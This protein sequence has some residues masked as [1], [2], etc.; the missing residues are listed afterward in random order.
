MRRL[1][2]EFDLILSSPFLRCRTTAEIVAEELGLAKK[3]EMTPRLEP[4]ASPADLVEELLARHAGHENILLVGHE[5]FLSTLISVLISGNQRAEIAVKKGGLCK[6]TIE[7]LRFGRCASLE[8][9]LAPAQ[10]VKL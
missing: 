10:L 4:S 3:L 7:S 5:P 9:L 6:V 2:T 8:W 1:K